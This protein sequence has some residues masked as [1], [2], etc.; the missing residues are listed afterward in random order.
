MNDALQRQYDV[1][2]LWPACK[3]VAEQRGRDLDAAR[4]AFLLHAM[5]SEAWRALGLPELRLQIEALK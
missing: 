4:G 5:N 2:F 1:R 3:L